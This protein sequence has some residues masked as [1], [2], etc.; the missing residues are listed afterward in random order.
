VTEEDAEEKKLQA[1]SSV[2][3]LGKRKATTHLPVREDPAKKAKQ[4][5]PGTNSNP[6]AS[7]V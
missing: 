5:T 2:N 3:V 4:A 6:S 7:E 1:L